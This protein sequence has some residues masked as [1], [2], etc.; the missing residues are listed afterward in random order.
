MGFLAWLILLRC[1]GPQKDKKGQKMLKALAKTTE[2][3]TP[4]PKKGPVSQNI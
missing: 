1:Q 4:E 3:T 2:T